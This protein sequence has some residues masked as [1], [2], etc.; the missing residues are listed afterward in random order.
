MWLK[1]AN[2]GTKPITIVSVA[3]ELAQNRGFLLQNT[4]AQLPKELAHG[5]FLHLAVAPVGEFTRE[6]RGIG[7]FDGLGRQWRVPRK[8][9][10]QLIE[11]SHETWKKDRQARARGGGERMAT[12]LEPLKQSELKALE[13]AVDYAVRSKDTLH[14][15]NDWQHVGELFAK[16]APWIIAE[17]KQRAG[18][19]P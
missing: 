9:I 7:V 18:R 1:I 8:R 17:L 2:E 5:Q 16:Y 10:R 11:D 19:K 12:T 13:E 3:V 6:V 4:V 14:E 15:V